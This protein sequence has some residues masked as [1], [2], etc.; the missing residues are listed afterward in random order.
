MTARAHVEE[1]FALD[2]MTRSTLGV[3]AELIASSS[4]G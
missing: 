3:Y 1:K 2:R 4:R